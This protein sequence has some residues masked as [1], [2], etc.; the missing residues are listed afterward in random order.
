MFEEKLVVAG[1][2]KISLF[3]IKL[4]CPSNFGPY[5]RSKICFG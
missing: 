1:I 4:L 5:V 2:R 3:G